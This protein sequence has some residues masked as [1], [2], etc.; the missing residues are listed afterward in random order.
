M[1]EIN[2]TELEDNILLLAGRFEGTSYHELCVR[3][4][5]SPKG[6]MQIDRTLQK[7]RRK[8]MI[9]FCRV[10]SLVRWVISVPETGAANA[11]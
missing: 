10:N 3:Y 11:D 9:S 7:L 8:G 1:S 2:Q 6:Q 5:A 4:D